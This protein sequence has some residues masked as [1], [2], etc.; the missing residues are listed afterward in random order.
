MEPG[1]GLAAFVAGL[2][3]AINPC[4]L[5]LLPIVFSAT[6]FAL[7]ADR[8]R[9]DPFGAGLGLALVAAGIPVY[10]AQRAHMLPPQ[11][12]PRY[13]VAAKR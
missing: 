4:V 3:T 7:V 1:T 10:L 2:L 5:P 11:P 6:A 13:E 12:V 8:L 9:S